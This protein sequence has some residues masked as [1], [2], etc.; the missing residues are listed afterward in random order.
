MRTILYIH[1]LIRLSA[2]AV[3]VAGVYKFGLIWRELALLMRI[4]GAKKERSELLGEMLDTSQYREATY[5]L[6]YSPL[7]LMV[8]GVLLFLGVRVVTRM[9]IG[10]KEMHTLLEL[11]S[12]N[13]LESRS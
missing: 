5:Q 7:F 1:V 8:L 4:A 13:G 6:L 11:D 3:F 10:K 9:I 12:K 2:C